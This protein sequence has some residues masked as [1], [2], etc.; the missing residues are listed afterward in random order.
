VEALDVVWEFIAFVLTA[1]AFL[2]LGLALSFDALVASALP[3]AA[4]VVAILVGRVAVVYG[5]LG[6]AARIFR[7]RTRQT[8]VPLRW[9]H[10]LYWAGLRGAVAVAMALSLP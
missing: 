4:G 2:L 3:I 8:E 10:V 5:L 6:G 1:F 9:L 7:G